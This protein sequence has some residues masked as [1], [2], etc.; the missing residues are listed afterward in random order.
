M[1]SVEPIYFDNYLNFIIY[2][3]PIVQK[4]N[5]NIYKKKRGNKYISFIGHTKKMDQERNRISIELYRQ[6]KKIGLYKPIDYFIEVNFIF[7]LE[8]QHEPDLDNLPAIVLDAA[9]GIIDKKSKR[10]IA[11]ILKDDKLVR[12]ETSRKVIKGDVNYS[13]EPRT[14]FSIRR[15]AWWRL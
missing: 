14:E 12:K 5:L 10:R 9:Q 8:K 2:G 3:K 4:N 11:S 1:G 6:Y 15:Y 7:Y 13:G